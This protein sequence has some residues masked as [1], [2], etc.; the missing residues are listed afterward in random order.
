MCKCPLHAPTYLPARKNFL[1][2]TLQG[3]QDLELLPHTQHYS[4]KTYN[5]VK[6]EG[7]QHTQ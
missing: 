7:K 5:T 3:V 6:Y 2:E 1:Y 4:H